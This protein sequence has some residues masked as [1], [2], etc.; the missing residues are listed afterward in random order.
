[1]GIVAGRQSELKALQHSRRSVQQ[2]YFLLAVREIHCKTI[3][4]NR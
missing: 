1:V 3:N 2:T 4:K